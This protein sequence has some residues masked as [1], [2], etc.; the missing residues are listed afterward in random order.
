MRCKELARFILFDC[1]KY[2]KHLKYSYWKPRVQ[3]HGNLLCDK[4]FSHILGWRRDSKQKP[5]NDRQLMNLI[6]T[7]ISNASS[8]CK[9]LSSSNL[10]YFWDVDVKKYIIVLTNVNLTT[11]QKQRAKILEFVGTK[12]TCFMSSRFGNRRGRRPRKLIKIFDH[13]IPGIC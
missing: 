5:S 3:W 13:F 9:K 11:H 8:I 1:R 12:S 2:L 4:I 10:S 7:A 6:R